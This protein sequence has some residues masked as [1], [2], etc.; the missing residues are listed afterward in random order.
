MIDIILS[1]ANGRMGQVLQT[2]ISQQSEMQIV[3]GIDRDV[4]EADF[5]TYQ[6]ITACQINADVVIDF[7]HYSAVPAVLDYCADRK[8]PVVIATT[9]LT[10]DI[11]EQMKS[12]ATQTAVFFSA[13]MSLGINLLAKAIRE[14]TPVLEEEF[15]IEIV[16]KHHNQ[17]KDAPSGTALLLADAVNDAVQTEKTYVYGRHG[18]DLENPLSELGIHAVRGGTIPGEHTVIY[19]G[20]DEVIELNHLALSRN[21]F[22][23]GAVKAAKYISKKTIGLYDMEKLIDE[24]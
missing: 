17:K 18:N 3:A 7:S 10:N 8:L 2:M 1:G 14:I 11:Q 5:P 15:N 9:G 20:P 22:A 19:A 16:E 12:A 23:S 24:S 13:N 4:F 21:I 6:T